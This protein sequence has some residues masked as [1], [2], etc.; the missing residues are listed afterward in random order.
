MKV[1][2]I[3]VLVFSALLLGLFWWY[4]SNKQESQIETQID[5]G[6]PILVKLFEGHA[7]LSFRGIAT[8]DDSV[9]WVSGNQGVFG[10]SLDYGAHWVFG[11]IPGADSLELR[12]I[13]LM[14]DHTAVVM[15][16]GYPTKI[17][18]TVDGGERWKTVFANADEQMFLDGMDFC[19]CGTGLAFGDPINGKFVLLRSDDEGDSWTWD[20]TN[21]PLALEGEAGF[22]ASGSSIQCFNGKRVVIGTGGTKAR[23]LYRA[24]DSQWSEMDQPMFAGTSSQGIFSIAANDSLVIVVGGDYQV[25]TARYSCGI[26]SGATSGFA[27]GG[28][29][30]FQ[31]SV[32]F[33]NDSTLISIGTPGGYVSRD[34]GRSWQQFTKDGMHTLAVVKS[35]EIVFAAGDNGRIA[36]IVFNKHQISP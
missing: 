11:R 34:F 32:V 8:V 5:R 22:A 3:P 10:K 35:G 33:A 2:F 26:W 21:A 18:K 1:K 4:G 25:D 29:L 31:S 12:D 19:S 15:S 17:F 30:P 6:L 9:V 14:D 13:E 16:S 7:D 28:E 20:S 36:K 24:D 27:K 23:V